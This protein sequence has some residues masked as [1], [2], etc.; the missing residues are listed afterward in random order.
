MTQIDSTTLNQWYVIQSSAALTP[1]QPRK[2]RLLGRDILAVRQ[3]DGQATAWEVSTKGEQ[4]Q[5]LPVRECYDYVWTTLGEPDGDIFSMPEFYEDGRRMVVC[6]IATVQTS[7][8]RIIEN[9]LDMSHFP[10]VHTDVLGA[11]PDTEVNNYKVNLRKDVNELWATECGFYQ[12]KAMASA[13]EGIE[14]DYQYRVANPFAAILYKTCP[15][16]AD[17]MDLVGILPQPLDETNCDIHYFM[18][19]FDDVNSDQELIQFQQG[20]LMQ[21]RVIL[22]NQ[23]PRE[24]PLQRGAEITIRADAASIQYRRWIKEM[25]VG[26]GTL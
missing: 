15:D 7:P 22:E 17:A 2:T 23:R 11:E 16:R 13:T 9:F 14:V 24:L 8:G 21:D 1:S 12:P 10:F 18:L 25:G 6:G 19:V 4:G 20:I 5:A 3:E 26:F